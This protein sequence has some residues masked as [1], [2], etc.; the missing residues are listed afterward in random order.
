MRGSCFLPN[1]WTQEVLRENRGAGRYFKSHCSVYMPSKAIFE[2]GH[3]WNRGLGVAIIRYTGRDGG[4]K[5][6]WLPG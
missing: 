1:F 5:E 6:V 2:V 4:G 3:G